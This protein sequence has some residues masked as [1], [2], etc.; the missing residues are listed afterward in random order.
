MIQLGDNAY[1]DTVI[2]E[3]IMELIEVGELYH[4]EVMPGYEFEMNH[5]ID[6]LVSI[7]FN[8]NI[9]FYKL[10]VHDM[11]VGVI[12][13]AI[14]KPISGGPLQAL[15]M[16]WFIKKEYRRGSLGT[17]MY[18]AIEALLEQE[19]GVGIIEMTSMESSDPDR[20]E[21]FL[22][23]SGYVPSERHYRKWLKET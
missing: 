22:L 6:N 3:D 10:V 20:V 12:A 7:I 16:F 19:K 14:T 13:F 5:L 2:E 21:S 15:E 11:I 4:E 23:R 17:R 1:L 9:V 8:D 18:K